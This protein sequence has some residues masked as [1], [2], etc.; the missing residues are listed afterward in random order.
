MSRD[1]APFQSSA[2]VNIAYSKPVMVL[3][4]ELTASA[5]ELFSAILQD[6]QRAILFGG[7]T[8]GAGGAVGQFDTGIYGET[9]ASMA[10]GILV[11]DRPVVTM[12]FPAAPYIENIGIRPDITADYMTLDNLSSKGK[13]FVDAF[14]T[15]MT[16]YIR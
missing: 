6:N 8:N 9:F 13:A 1:I 5:A 3:V 12:D 10:V 15:A 14:T 4:D 2:K 11:R 16:D 7:R